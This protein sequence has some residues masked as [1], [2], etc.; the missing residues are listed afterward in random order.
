MDAQ[1]LD[2]IS[3][4]KISDL[5]E[6]RVK[7][8]TARTTSI[9]LSHFDGQWAA[10][11]NHCPHQGGP[12]GEGSI[13]RGSDGKCWIRCPWH[14]W[15]FDPIS[16]T[17]P[18]GH[19]DTGQKLYPL[20]I[21][22]EEI[23]IGLEPEPERERTVSD[24]MA[25][26]MVNWGVKRVFGMVGHS[27]LGLAEALR[28]QV[29]KGALGYV[30]I[31]HEGAAAFAASAYGKLT[32]KPAACL[33]IAGPGATNLLTGL[34]DAKV[35]RA[36]VLALT[37]Q[38][39][40][41]VFGPGAF[42]D[43]DLKSAFEAVS[44][45]SQPVLPSSNHA[46]LMSLALK[47][48]LVERDVSNLIFPDDVQTIPSDAPARGPEGRLGRTDVSPAAADLEDAARMINEAKRPVIVLGYGAIEVRE[49]IIAF[50]EKIG[51]PVMTT[52]K[53]KGLIPDTHQNAAGVLGRSGTPIASWF[54]NEADLII[55]LGSSFSNHTGIAPYKPIIQ[56]DFER[57]QLGKFHA[58]TLPVWSEL[59]AFCGSL[60]PKVGKA[61]GADDQIA[62]NVE[63]WQIWRD[64]KEMRLAEH[65]GQGIHSAAL[66][67]ALTDVCP[68]DAVIPVDVGNNT[69]SF[70]RYFEPR[71]QRIL[72]SGYLGSIGFALP[73]ALGAWCATQDSDE[74][75][76]RKV[77]S[78]SGDGGFGQYAMEF[79]TAVKYGMNI[80][81]I[82]LNNGEL[83]KISKEQKAGEWPVWETSLTNPSFSA[84]ARL[85]GGHGVRVTE[86]DQLHDALS[87]AFAH[88]GPSLVEVMTDADLV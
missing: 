54:M 52:F 83:G 15:D 87:E 12:L 13:E 42:Q 28:N 62:E 66:F 30:G 88:K 65:R 51:A 50:A 2:W 73:A 45:F 47:N 17:P 41:Q 32:G 43:I 20:K 74:F 55:A 71:G 10:M 53:G 26:T 75:K 72:M 9:C 23:F 24:V 60:M 77:I 27:N 39:Q 64:E 14:G 6:G 7:T 37:G 4:G 19:E 16:G 29:N 36:P 61:P 69:Y 46:E 44:R 59:S 5:P 25:E 35:D 84:F 79:T 68:Q 3:V 56:V 8:V 85:C 22:A 86:A 49:Q 76:G 48:A 67:K 11:D 78:I 40:T 38:V 1:N 33:T 34:W 80:T 58:V 31:R 81:H 21:E 63:R 70:G 57:M 18:G 82:L